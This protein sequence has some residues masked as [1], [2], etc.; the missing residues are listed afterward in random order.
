VGQYEQITGMAFGE[1]DPND[2][3]NTVIQDIGLAPRNQR[4]NVEYSMNFA[5]LKPVD[6]SRGNHTLIYDVVNRGNTREPALNIGGS[7]TAPGD[8]LVERQGFTVVWSGWEGDITGGF[9][10][11]LPTAKNPDG[12]EITG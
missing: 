5:I 10:I 3:A 7:N 8:G 1:V 4:G 9:R 2:P 12:S 11:N 6:M